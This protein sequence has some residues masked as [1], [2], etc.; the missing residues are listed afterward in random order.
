[1]HIRDNVEEQRGVIDAIRQIN[2]V[3]RL[4]ARVVIPRALCLSRILRISMSTDL[5][6]C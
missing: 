2:G 5:T 1:M 3:F 6:I 4:Q